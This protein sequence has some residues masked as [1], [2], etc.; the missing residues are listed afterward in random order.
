M[1]IYTKKEIERKLNIEGI[2]RSNIIKILDFIE[3]NKK[4]KLNIL[5]SVNDFEEKCNIIKDTY[6]E[7]NYKLEVSRRL[8]NI[9][10][11]DIRFGFINRYELNCTGFKKFNY[12]SVPS[13]LNSIYKLNAILIE[14]KQK[15]NEESHYNNEICIY[16]KV[17]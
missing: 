15:C 16:R 14:D 3:D 1:R 7:D 9:L 2:E 13:K 8:I 10:E 11:T 4:Y 17:I 6:I 12:K 5:S